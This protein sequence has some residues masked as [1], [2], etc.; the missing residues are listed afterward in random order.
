M[1]WMLVDVLDLC[2]ILMMVRAIT[3]AITMMMMRLLMRL[4]MMLMLHGAKGSW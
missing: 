3:I 2:N 4:L 1:G